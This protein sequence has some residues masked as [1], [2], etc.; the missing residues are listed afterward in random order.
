MRERPPTQSAVALRYA[1]G[2]AAPRVVARGRGLMAEEIARRAREAGLFVHESPALV[3]LLMRVDL[4]KHIPPELYHAVA[5][6]MVW[7]WR[8]DREAAARRNPA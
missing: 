6:V 1:Q 5:E 2:D 7:A 4:D 3:A 8:L